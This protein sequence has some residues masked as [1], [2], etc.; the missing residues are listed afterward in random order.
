[1]MMKARGEAMRPEHI[2]FWQRAVPFKP[3][4]I[5]LNSGRMYEIRHPEMIRV[6]RSTAIVFSFAGDP[7]EPFESMEMIGLV[8]IERIEPMEAPAHA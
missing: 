3:F 6:G 2:Q 1:M 5:C 4:W 8:L 7:D